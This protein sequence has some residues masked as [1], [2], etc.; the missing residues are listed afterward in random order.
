MTSPSPTAMS[1]NDTAAAAIKR[2]FSIP[3]GDKNVRSDTMAYGLQHHSLSTSSRCNS[4]CSTGSSFAGSASPTSPKTGW[5]VISKKDVHTIID[6]V[7]ARMICDTVAPPEDA[8]I[9]QENM[10]GKATSVEQSSYNEEQYMHRGDIME[11]KI[12]TEKIDPDENVAHRENNNISPVNTIS[13]ESIAS[14]SLPPSE[15]V[16]S[17]T[18]KDFI[19]ICPQGGSSETPTGHLSRAFKWKSSLLMRA[20]EQ[21]E[22]RQELKVI[23][24]LTAKM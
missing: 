4:S 17:S 3:P 13:I 14:R 6:N 7:V 23:T 16:E 22:P 19:R 18:K 21:K 5:V 11:I 15:T 20:T 10:N 9:K 1:T 12:K 24:A 2:L 8:D